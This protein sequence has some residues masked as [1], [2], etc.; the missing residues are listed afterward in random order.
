MSYTNFGS[1]PVYRKALELCHM[2]REI[3]S[4]VTFNKNLLQLY[5]SAS[6]RDTIANALLT[7]A[8]LI[9]KKIALAETTANPSERVQIATYINVIIRNIN[10]YCRGLEHDGVKETEYLDL[11]RNELRS[12]RKSFKIWSSSFREE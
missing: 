3:A 6:L 7:D 10:S 9:P 12:F 8:I 11:L 5:K 4:Y 1:L 2:S